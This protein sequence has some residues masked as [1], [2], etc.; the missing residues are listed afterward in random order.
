MCVCVF[1]RS[2]AMNISKEV[3]IF[4]KCEIYRKDLGEEREVEAESWNAL[5]ESLLGEWPAS[6]G[7][8]S[9]WGAELLLW[10]ARQQALNKN[11]PL[12]ARCT[13]RAAVDEAGRWTGQS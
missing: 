4:F 7:R 2:L 5:E 1:L 13:G 10:L 9:P 12:K 8:K 3:D 6:G 11:G